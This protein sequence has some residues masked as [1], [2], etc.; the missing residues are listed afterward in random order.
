MTTKDQ[1]ITGGAIAMTIL[2]AMVITDKLQKSEFFDHKPKEE[3]IS[4][5]KPKSE[6]KKAAPTPSPTPSLTVK[7]K[8]GPFEFEYSR[9]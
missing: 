5:W 4:W 6:D 3:K 7:K 2:G 9:K 1:L 8:W